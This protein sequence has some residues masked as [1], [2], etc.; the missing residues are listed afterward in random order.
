MSNQLKDKLASHQSFSD[1]YYIVEIQKDDDW[2]IVCFSY[3]KSSESHSFVKARKYHE[4]VDVG[5]GLLEELS[6]DQIKIINNKKENIE[7]NY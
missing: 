6:E 7:E 4:G 3:D 2:Y 5:S 1:I